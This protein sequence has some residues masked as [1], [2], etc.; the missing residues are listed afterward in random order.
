MVKEWGLRVAEPACA[1]AAK[2]CPPSA[3]KPAGAG[4]GRY[5]NRPQKGGRQVKDV[6]A[7]DKPAGVPSVIRQPSGRGRMFAWRIARYKTARRQE[8]KREMEA[9][10][11]AFRT[12][13]SR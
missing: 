12:L 5:F 9:E 4:R 13:C 3:P 6:A 7:Q 10:Q 8:H 11:P 2:P 1:P